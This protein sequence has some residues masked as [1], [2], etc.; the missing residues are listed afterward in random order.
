MF[1]E[2]HLII[3]G[4]I[5]TAMG[6]LS[7]HYMGMWAE[8]TQVTMEMDTCIFVV[9]IFI[10]AAEASVGFW[11]FFR[12]LTIWPM[13]WIRVASALIMSLAVCETHYVSMSVVKY[14]YDPTL[15]VDT[16]G[17]LNAEVAG[18][19]ASHCSLIV[20]Y[21][22]CAWGIV[23]KIDRSAKKEGSGSTSSMMMRS[24]RS[25]SSSKRS[26]SWKKNSMVVPLNTIDSGISKS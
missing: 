19:I 25:S 17:L 22:L 16:T 21:L 24:D 5:I 10:T 6:I 14:S 4:G 18:N 20:C 1:K 7:M 9:S 11:V 15:N 26:L 2:L 23:A 12:L 13:E 8:R 3:A